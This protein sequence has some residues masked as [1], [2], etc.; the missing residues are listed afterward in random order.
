MWYPSYYPAFSCIGGACRHS[1]CMGWE[2]DIDPDTYAFYRTLSGNLRARFDH[3][4]EEG[5]P[6]H[7]RLQEGERCP[8][9]NQGNWCEIILT[10]GD[11]A[12]CEICREHPRYYNE[13]SYGLE[14]GL[15]MTCEEAARLILSQ[16]EPVMLIADDDDREPIGEDLWECTLLTHRQTVLTQ[17]QDRSRP[18]KERLCSLLATVRCSL[19]AFEPSVSLL[20]SLEILTP[21]WRALLASLAEQSDWDTV[22]MA[23]HEREYEQIAVYLAYRYLIGARD[24][25]DLCARTIFCAFG[26]VLLAT[27]AAKRKTAF[28]D[29]VE[30]A[31]LFSTELEYSDENLDTLFSFFCESKE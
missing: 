24:D 4:I 29:R 25:D 11:S 14:M 18:L 10:L 27:L 30:L 6:P 12:L 1:C 28:A 15:G 26:P 22:P 2:I 17:L 21:E 31:R 13:T 20:T 19:P 8:F 5:D 16:E 23:E 7:F 9:L 3:A